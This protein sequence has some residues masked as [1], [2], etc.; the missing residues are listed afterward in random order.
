VTAIR[1]RGA[2]R[3]VSALVLLV[4]AALACAT[5]LRPA[6]D[7]EVA[8][9]P[10]RGAV[11]RAAGVRVEAR[12]G[13]WR[14]EPENLARALTPVQ[15]EIDN[16]S[17]RALRIRYEEFVLVDGAG[18]RFAALPPFD[19]EADVTERR[20]AYT[21]AYGLHGF[22]VA[23][24]LSYYYPRASVHHGPFLH[25]PHYYG[26]GYPRLREIELPTND[27]LARALPEGVLD[28]DAG[29]TG[30]VY[31]EPVEEPAEDEVAF[32]LVLVDAANGERFGT[33]EIPFAAESGLRSG[34]GGPARGYGSD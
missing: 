3:P 9:G 20:P 30:F 1:R 17:G 10:G 32:R 18:E 12:V 11:D 24:H 13:A 8:P 6:P 25:H 27:M 19:I 2:W 15:V 21:T 31:F 16:H 14:W 29:V 22:H 33:V 7:A 5:Q 4:A 26:T 34:G 28:P 23:P